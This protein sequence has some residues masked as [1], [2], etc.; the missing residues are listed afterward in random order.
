MTLT[1]QDDGGFWISGPLAAAIVAGILGAFGAAY[2]A[3]NDRLWN[4]TQDI[5]QLKVIITN[6]STEVNKLEASIGSIN[7]TMASVADS[8]R[9]LKDGADNLKD[10]IHSLQQQVASLED[11]LRPARGIGNNGR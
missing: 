5:A 8:L 2:M 10:Q 11:I 7:Q 4:D 1:K 9:G 6:D 3:Q